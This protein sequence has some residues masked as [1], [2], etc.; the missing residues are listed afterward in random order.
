[1][2]VTGINDRHIQYIQSFYDDGED[3]LAVCFTQG[4]AKLWKDCKTFQFDMNFKR[5]NGKKDHE[6]IFARRIDD[7]FSCKSPVMH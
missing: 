7:K 2:S 4:M 6:V 5:V 1:M 3:F